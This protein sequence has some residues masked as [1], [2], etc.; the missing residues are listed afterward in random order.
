VDSS[1]RGNDVWRKIRTHVLTE[2][3]DG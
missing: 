2:I 1:F 3:A